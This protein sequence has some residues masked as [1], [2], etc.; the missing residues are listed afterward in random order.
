MK[1]NSTPEITN[2]ETDTKGQEA[3]S[4]IK[5]W[6]RSVPETLEEIKKNGSEEDLQNYQRQIN[7][8]LGKLENI[9][10]DMEENK[11]V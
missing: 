4:T 9:V 11:K 10:K 7:M 5:D 8:V 3:Y 1:D 2:S 6:I